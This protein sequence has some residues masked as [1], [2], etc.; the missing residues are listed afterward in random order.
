MVKGSNN[1]GS[2]R[3]WEAHSTNDAR[4]TNMMPPRADWNGSTEQ[5]LSGIFLEFLKDLYGLGTGQSGYFGPLK[6]RKSGTLWHFEIERY[7]C[8][9][10]QE[11]KE[12]NWR[13]SINELTGVVESASEY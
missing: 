13:F 7:W 5:W 4:D 9:A 1:P 10:W 2:T 3:R 12:V 11:G 6:L 8:H